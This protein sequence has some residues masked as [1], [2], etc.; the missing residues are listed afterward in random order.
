MTGAVALARR[1]AAADERQVFG[2]RRVPVQA[3]GPGGAGR[4]R[5]GCVGRVG[6]VVGY[7]CGREAGD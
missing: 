2:V 4:E 6:E 3:A 5:D 1:D 7:G